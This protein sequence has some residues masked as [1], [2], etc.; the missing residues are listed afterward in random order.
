MENTLI[1]NGTTWCRANNAQWWAMIN[2]IMPA[3]LSHYVFLWLWQL[4]AFKDNRLTLLCYIWLLRTDICVPRVYCIGL[5]I[6]LKFRDEFFTCE[7]AV[8]QMRRLFFL[9]SCANPN[10]WTAIKYWHKSIVR[11]ITR[12]GGISLYVCKVS[13][14]FKW[15][16][17]EYTLRACVCDFTFYS[18]TSVW[19]LV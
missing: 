6:G 19:P 15:A 7:K 8:T 18:T 11:R 9:I 3:V 12:T 1:P 5:I 2:K 10:Y 14:D 4:I 16:S 13:T 17:N